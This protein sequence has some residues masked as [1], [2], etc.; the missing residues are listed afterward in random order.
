MIA[1]HC[2]TVVGAK[3]RCGLQ[4]NVFA[5]FAN[6]ASGASVGIETGSTDVRRSL[7]LIDSK[8]CGA[9]FDAK[10]REEGRSGSK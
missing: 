7:V 10:D 3:T 9:M 1:R 5:Q 2:S 6:S 4:R 8:S